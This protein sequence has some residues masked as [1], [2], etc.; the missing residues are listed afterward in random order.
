MPLQ[1]VTVSV[2]MATYRG[3]RFILDQL[4]SIAAQT[5]LPDE[6]VVTDDSPDSSTFDILRRFA[7][8]A[9]FPVRILKNETRLGYRGN[10]LKA[11]SLCR[12]DLIA[13]CDQDDIWKREKIECVV[14]AFSAEDVLLVIHDVEV[15]SESLGQL[16]LRPTKPWSVTGIH[17]P[18]TT[19]PWYLAYGMSMII[20]RELLD[21]LGYPDLTKFRDDYGH[22]TW[23]WF[24]AT[25]LGSI[26][27]MKER[28]ALYRQHPQNAVGAP[29]SASAQEDVS[30]SSRTGV[31]HYLHLASMALQLSAELN[32]ISPQVPTRILAR[33]RQAAIYYS[34]LAKYYQ[35]RASLYGPSSL[36]DRLKAISR[37]LISGAYRPISKRGLGCKAL[38]KDAFCS[39]LQNRSIA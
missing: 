31:K 34:T 25:S 17:R 9:P 4:N 24:A 33:A 20:R 32:E 27:G 5:H 8:T 26:A 36:G 16:E 19:N 7:E 38:L 10:F 28:L 29:K 6:L 13:L 35:F 21:W 23:L 18:L 37:L 39:I 1:R 22:D 14:R 3:E 2:A 11:M 30:T 12:G 15:V